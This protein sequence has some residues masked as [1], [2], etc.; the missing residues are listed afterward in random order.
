MAAKEV[1]MSRAGAPWSTGAPWSPWAPSSCLLVSGFPN[2]G[3]FVD[4]IISFVEGKKKVSL[5]KG[6]GEV[7][8]IY[9]RLEVSFIEG[10]V[11]VSFIEARMGSPSLRGEWRSP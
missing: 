1:V 10:R 9:G 4:F 2:S 8:L 6:K 11:E 3:V 5:I 7:S